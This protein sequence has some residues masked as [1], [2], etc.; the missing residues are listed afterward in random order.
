VSRRTL[1]IESLA[2]F[3][4]HIRRARS[5]NG[6]FVSSLDLTERSEDLLRVKVR[7]AVFLGCSFTPAVEERLR[8]SGALLFPQLPEVPFD[9]YRPRLYEADELYGSGRYGASPDAVIYAWARSDRARLL[10]GE[11]AS[12]LHDHAITDALNDA[13]D[14]LDPRQVVGIMGGHRLLRTE[15]AYADAAR[16]AAGLA[17]AGRTVLTGGGPGAMEAGNLGAYLSPWSGAVEAALALLATVPSY[18]TDLDRWV[19]TARQ[20]RDRWPPDGAGRSLSIP[21]WFYGHEPSNLFATGIAK[22]FANA[23]RED[24]LLHRCRGGI[25]YLAGQAGT[26][27]EVFQ[28]VT[29]NF[30]AADPSQVAPMILVGVEYWTQ[31]LPAWPL[32]QRLGQDRPMGNAIA[33]VDDVDEALRLLARAG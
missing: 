3:D 10:S 25:V 12:T 21:T 11:L 31:I 9:P 19:D 29:E 6:W 7:G 15:P 23:L 13:T 22:Y 2:D 14:D 26:V 18:H 4:S 28:A 16:L 24:T 1:E 32:L 20:V 27:Q 17:R 8:L 5:L 30:Y 33:C